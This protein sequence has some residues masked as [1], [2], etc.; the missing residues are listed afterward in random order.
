MEA[1]DYATASEKL[2]QSYKLDPSP[3]TLLNL[4]IC[5]DRLGRLVSARRYALATLDALEQGDPRRPLAEKQVTLLND[6]VPWLTVRVHAPDNVSFTVT[7]DG[8]NVDPSALAQPIPLDPGNHSVV[9]SS[10][11]GPEVRTVRLAERQ[12][13]DLFVAIS[14]P[15]ADEAEP[16]EQG[17]ST[18]WIGASALGIGVVGFGLGFYLNKQSGDFEEE[19]EWLFEACNPRVCTQEERTRIDGIDDQADSA[20]SKSLLAFATGAVAVAVGGIVLLAPSS[21]DEAKPA[22]TSALRIDPWLAG[23]VGGVRGVF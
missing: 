18:A 2:A 10:S 7:I 11:L 20:G 1:G 15:A 12:R 4:S 8:R 17:T 14:A 22:K 23:G 16:E 19:A 6:R 3:G 9:V 5:E 21:D 13:A